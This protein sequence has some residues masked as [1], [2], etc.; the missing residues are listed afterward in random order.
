MAENREGRLARWSRLKA[1][2]KSDNPEHVEAAQSESL[3][4]DHAGLKAT[5]IPFDSAKLPGGVQ[6]REFVPP[7]PP[8]AR[9]DSAEEDVPSY[10]A[11][12]PEAVGMVNAERMEFGDRENNDMFVEEE[13][14]AGRELTPDEKEAVRDLPRLDSLNEDSDFR[15]FLADN[16]PEFIRNRALKILW[17]SNPFFGFQ[18]GLDDYAENFRVIDKVINAATDSIYQPGKGYDFPEED[19][20]EGSHIE[21]DGIVQDGAPIE[22]SDTEMA[23]VSELGQG[24]V[25]EGVVG[26]QGSPSEPDSKKRET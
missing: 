11:P 5:D 1:Q 19:A 14:S 16:I 2:R 7:M 10:E 26:N 24:V 17:R 4:V 9:L 20:D 8:L 25:P 21:Q 6:K 3:S 22:G 18:D 15:P 12:P 13:S 23:G